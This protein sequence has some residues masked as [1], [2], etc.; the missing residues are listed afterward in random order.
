MQ[1][2]SKHLLCLQVRWPQL[3]GWSGDQLS[4][5]GGG[6]VSENRGPSS[7]SPSPWTGPGQGLEL[8]LCRRACTPPVQLPVS[9]G[10][11]GKADPFKWPLLI[12]SYWVFTCLLLVRVSFIDQ[13]KKFSFK[14]RNSTLDWLLQVAVNSLS[15]FNEHSKCKSTRLNV[16]HTLAWLIKDA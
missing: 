9:A 7:P 3:W 12:L 6:T 11:N 13:D 4:W 5:E 1:T 2:V 15:P 10:P 14:F 16:L 8:D